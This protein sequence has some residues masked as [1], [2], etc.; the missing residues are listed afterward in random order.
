MV[1][2]ETAFTSQIAKNKVTDEEIIAKI[3]DMLQ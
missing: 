1:K 3:F 2:D